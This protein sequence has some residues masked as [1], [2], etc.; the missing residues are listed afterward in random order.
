MKSYNRIALCFCVLIFLAWSVILTHKYLHFSYEDWDLAMFTQACWQLL[1]GTQYVP[2]IGVNYFGD[3]SYF[4]T[5]LTL[6]F[7]AMFQSPL[8]LLYLK[9]AAFALSAWLLYRICE[10]KLGGGPALGLMA[11]YIFFPPNIYSLLYEYNPESLAPPILFWMFMAFDKQRWK[12]FFWAAILLMTIKENMCLITGAFGLYAILDKR[13]PARMGWAALSLAT[14]AFLVL[15]MWVIPHMRHLPQHAFVVRYKMFG[16]SVGEILV[17]CLTRPDL[18]LGVLVKRTNIDYIL[19]LFGLFL[20][21]S[22]IGMRWMVLALPILLQHLLSNHL[23]EHTIFYHYNATISPFIFLATMQALVYCGR[24]LL[25]A[26]SMVCLGAFTVFQ[27][28]SYGPDFIARIDLHRDGLQPVRQA[29]V[30][31][32]PKDA[33]VIATFDYLA[34]LSLR[35]DLYSF[36]KIYDEYYQTAQKIKQ[37]ELN[38]AQ[39]FILPANVHYALLDFDDTWFLY[40]RQL[41]PEKTAWW[42]RSFMERYHW[43]VVRRTKS[44]VLLE[45]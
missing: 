16:N 6:P 45:R 22:L 36:H 40:T 38:T 14:V 32:I 43:K 41:F 4:I 37:S 29:F 35:R 44:L 27:L 13:Y 31:A 25:S 18:V 2:L 39:S 10:E 30:A 12:S 7:F 34:P 15:A 11:L 3:H 1:H 26:A 17:N 8:T 9:V 20:V 33:G 21:P 23:P 42:V 24:G 19:E 5:F 28:S